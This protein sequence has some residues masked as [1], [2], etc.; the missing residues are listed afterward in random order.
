VA[1]GRDVSIGTAITHDNHGES[2][3]VGYEMWVRGLE[4]RIGSIVGASGCFYGIRASIYDAHFPEHLSRD[5]AS[6]LMARARGFR[7][8]SVDDAVCY[9]PRAASLQSEFR[10][11]IRTMSRGIETLWQ[12]RRMLDPVRYGAFAVMLFSHKLCRWLVYLTLPSAIVGL[13]ALA[14]TFPIAAVALIPAVA[15]LAVGLAVL[16]RGRSAGA[17]TRLAALL[18]FGVA[19]MLAGIIAWTTVLRRQHSPVWE[20]TR[21]PT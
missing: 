21:R 5:F 4:T 8:V 16:R 1:S 6:A 7:A 10:R 18:G 12:W 14:S 13:L 11:K 2:G 15:G 3:Y 20:P 19:S 17:T 9:V